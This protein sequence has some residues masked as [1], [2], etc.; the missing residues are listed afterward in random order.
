[1]S[2]RTVGVLVV[3]WGYCGGWNLRFFGRPVGS[4]EV[5]YI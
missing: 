1:V 4:E 2:L 5:F 3:V